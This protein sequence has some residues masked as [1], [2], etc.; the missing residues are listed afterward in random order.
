MDDQAKKDT[1]FI[2]YTMGADGRHTKSAG[3]NLM[4]AGNGAD[5]PGEPAGAIPSGDGSEDSRHSHSQNAF[6][7]WIELFL[8]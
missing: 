1:G 7:R 3:E 5:D 8:D 4:A 6:E 2:P